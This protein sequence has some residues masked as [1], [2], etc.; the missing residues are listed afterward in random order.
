MP[1]QIKLFEN[2]L[3][4]LLGRKAEILISALKPKELPILKHAIQW[5]YRYDVVLEQVLACKQRH[6]AFRDDASEVFS[7]V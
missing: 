5:L 7:Y 1:E 4:N 6:T 3:L 2:L